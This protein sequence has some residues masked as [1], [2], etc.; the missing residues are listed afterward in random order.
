MGW[1]GLQSLSTTFYLHGTG[2]N[3]NPPTLVLDATAPAATTAKFKD[4]ASINRNNG[5]PWVAVGTWQA[6][7]AVTFTSGLV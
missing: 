7:A 4:S 1:S 3:D 6:G 5:N 2:P